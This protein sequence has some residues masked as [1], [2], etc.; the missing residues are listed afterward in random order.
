V[1]GYHAPTTTLNNQGR[2]QWDDQSIILEGLRYI[3]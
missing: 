2:F 1:Q 3:F